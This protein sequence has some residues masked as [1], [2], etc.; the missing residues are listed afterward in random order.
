[1]QTPR[2]LIGRHCPELDGIRSVAILLVLFFH[3]RI[4]AWPKS[5][6]ERVYYLLAH[7]CWIGVDLF[8]VLSGYLIT[9]ILLDSFTRERY[10][11]NFYVRRV[12]RIFPLYYGV[13]TVVTIFSAFGSYS[14]LEQHSPWARLSYWVHSQNWLGWFGLQP[15]ELLGHFWSLAIEEQFYLVW[16]ALV[17]FAA[18]RN[19]VA[20]LCLGTALLAILARLALV[21][22]HGYLAYFF[23]FSRLDT[24]ALGALVAVL[25]RRSG[26]LEPF[27]RQA[28]VLAGISATIVAGLGLKQRGFHGQDPLVLN[29]GLLP[30]ALFF[31]CLLVIVL[32]AEEDSAVR[33]VLRN[34][35]LRTIGVISYGIYVFHWPVIA[36]LQSAWPVI[37]SFW[38]NQIGMLLTA[39]A[40]SITLAWVSYRY[41]E[42]P[43]LRLKDR[44][45]PK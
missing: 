11:Q 6:G 25:L 31:A 33:V 22:S 38:V 19:S 37:D 7:S 1:M 17:L 12:L 16:P 41:F 42:S 2:P 36:L 27:R 40:L 23:T 44:F 9:G 10:F 45:A 8:F 26:S 43:F 4:I 20:W 35:W 32:S 21:R 24:L 13:L 15:T 28:F 29:Y 30:L 5:A 39:S 14:V 18:R 3:C 34:D